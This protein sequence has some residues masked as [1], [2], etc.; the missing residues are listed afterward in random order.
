MSFV[1][2]ADRQDITRAGMMYLLEQMDGFH[3]YAE[4]KAELIEQL[5]NMPMLWWYSTIRCSISTMPTNFFYLLSSV[6][7]Y[8]GCCLAKT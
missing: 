5:L 2:L 4:D 6:S 7:S 3:R 1:S 8:D